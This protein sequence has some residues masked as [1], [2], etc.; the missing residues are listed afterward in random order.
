MNTLYS[1]YAIVHKDKVIFGP[2]GWNKP[3]FQN[4]IKEDLEIDIELEH[5]NVE[6]V[7]VVVDDDTVILP[8]EHLARPEY[9]PK[10]E[11]LNGPYWAFYD[12]HAAMF[13]VAEPLK[14][15]HAKSFLKEQVAAIRYTKEVSSFQHLIGNQHVTIDTSREGRKNFSDAYMLMDRDDVVDWKFNEGWF[16]LTYPM[17]E[18]I[19]GAVRTH[20]QLAFSWERVKALEIDDARDHE[21]LDKIDIS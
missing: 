21:T 10:I 17:L 5:R 8:I 20:V 13:Y 2:K 14:L 7:P 18:K 4:V 12:D 6:A 9:N 16:T 15:E 3:Q 19:V 1:T 11:F